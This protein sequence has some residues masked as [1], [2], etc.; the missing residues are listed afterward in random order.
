MTLKINGTDITPYL[1]AGS[2]NWERKDMAGGNA[3][4]MQDGT[5]Y[6]DRIAYK[7]TFK[8]SCRLLTAAEQATVLAL[9]APEYVTLQY[10]D[11][12]TNSTATGQFY[13][14]STPANYLVRRPDST[15]YWAGLTFS[16]IQQ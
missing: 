7:Y 14:E 4:T 3:M 5:T 8:A 15:E 13:C 12:Q 1:L 9:L 2:I 16:L 6:R 11:P 10:T